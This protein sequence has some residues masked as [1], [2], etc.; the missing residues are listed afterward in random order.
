[1]ELNKIINESNQVVP[2]ES[3][4]SH[5]KNQRRGD[6][7]S[8][9]ESMRINGFYG[10][11]VVQ[12]STNYI[13]AG[14]HRWRAA[15]E[16]G[17]TEV[18]VC[19]VDVD[20]ERALRMLLADNRTS[21]IAGYDERGLADLLLELSHSSQSFEGTGYTQEDYEDLLEFLGGTEE[22]PEMKIEEMEEEA[23]E[24]PKKE[25]ELTKKQKILNEIS[26]A[27]D[28]LDNPEFSEYSL[29]VCIPKEDA[30]EEARDK[31]CNALLDVGEG[32]ELESP[33]LWVYGLSLP[34][35]G[36]SPDDF[37][38]T[39]PESAEEEDGSLQVD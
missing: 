18:P 32:G 6:L 28:A 24:P 4:Y 31:L 37:E 27:I 14:N 13:I 17:F 7:G 38:S 15:F 16:L 8:I 39:E 10:S 30:S 9:V 1:M 2:I 12:R 26:K 35:S 34:L 19:F 5:P 11:L 3:I 23:I 33:S 22:I 20:D 36:E 29:V 25:K 21:D